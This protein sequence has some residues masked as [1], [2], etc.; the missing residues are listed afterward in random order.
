MEHQDKA[1]DSVLRMHHL[2]WKGCGC[3][4]QWRQILNVYILV[5]ARHW[6]PLGGEGVGLEGGR[7]GAFCGLCV[8]CGS[9][10]GIGA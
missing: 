9:T 4:G 10:D 2:A 6:T 3:D 8:L 7:I 5:L 1:M